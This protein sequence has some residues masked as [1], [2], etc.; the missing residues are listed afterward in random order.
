MF[1]HIIYFSG[2]TLLHKYLF[3]IMKIHYFYKNFR[4]RMSIISR[5]I[6][7]IIKLFNSD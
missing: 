3:I 6:I 5:Y 4:L 1:L 2:H 7:I